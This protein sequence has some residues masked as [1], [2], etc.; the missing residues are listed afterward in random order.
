MRMMYSG[1]PEVPITKQTN[2]IN[3][4]SEVSHRFQK[5]SS[6]GKSPMV[7]PVNVDMKRSDGSE[8]IRYYRSKGNNTVG[9]SS[10]QIAPIQMEVKRLSI[11][12]VNNIHSD[13]HIPRRSARGECKGSEFQEEEGFRCVVPEDTTN[14]KFLPRE[15]RQ[16]SDQKAERSQ[17]QPSNVHRLR[18][19]GRANEVDST[20]YGY[21]DRVEPIKTKQSYGKPIRY[22][23]ANGRNGW[24]RVATGECVVKKYNQNGRWMSV[25]PS[26]D[27]NSLH[28]NGYDSGLNLIEGKVQSW[29]GNWVTDNVVKPG[30]TDKKK[31]G[32][33]DKIYIPKCTPSFAGVGT[34]IQTTTERTMEPR[35]K[36]CSNRG[37]TKPRWSQ[38]IGIK[39]LSG[40]GN[41]VSG[42]NSKTDR[43]DH[44]MTDDTIRNNIQNSTPNFAGVDTITLTTTERTIEPR[45]IEG[46]SNRGVN[47]LRRSQT[48]GSK[49]QSGEGDWFSGCISKTNGTDQMMTDNFIRNNIQRDKPNLA[50]VDTDTQ[51]YWSRKRNPSDRYMG[52]R[53]SCGTN[54]NFYQSKRKTNSVDDIIDW[55]EEYPEEES[56]SSQSMESETKRTSEWIDPEEKTVSRINIK[57]EGMIDIPN[58]SGNMSSINDPTY[59]SSKRTRVSVLREVL[60]GHE[61]RWMR[62]NTKSGI[63]S[64]NLG[65]NRQRWVRKHPMERRN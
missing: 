45:R 30:Y 14:N 16:I 56:D 31:S 11:G 52:E 60:G 65:V 35:S 28:G 50:G 49:G 58:T 20:G 8:G 24:S 18:N 7:S 21:N 64:A 19:Q 6:S 17:N 23:F 2:I 10:S 22:N 27:D 4:T 12:K 38:A 51:I 5:I 57:P 61:P 33:T 46:W 13:P 42:C 63:S 26:G 44:M 32:E 39:G 1:D 29:D 9:T 54:N 53:V 36:V 25:T 37:V 47:N 15:K 62:L 3:D 59:D 55:I 41:W 34:V 40:R 48:T 43:T